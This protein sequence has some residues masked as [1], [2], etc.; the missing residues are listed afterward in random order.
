MSGLGAISG[1][2]AA[3]GLGV[4][5]R[6]PAKIEVRCGCGKRYRVAAKK[7]GRS[8]RCKSCSARVKVEARPE[9][10]SSNEAKLI[11]EE[12]GIDAAV[13]EDYQEAVT[14]FFC[15]A[16]LNTSELECLDEGENPVC[17]TCRASAA[18]AT[19]SER[20]D[21]PKSKRPKNYKELDRWNRARPV[22][23][24]RWRAGGL[25]ALSLVGVTGFGVSVLGL[26]LVSAL[27]LAT[28]AAS[29]GGH[30]VYQATLNG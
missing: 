26:G 23:E 20:G 5:E 10:L 2:G 28:V 6:P 14:C 4:I 8:F 11:L 29:L 17:F 1:L 7:A 12:L 13:R 16:K 22:S 18:D 27:F 25:A 9:S 19:V 15:A 3:S 24:A 30:H 21:E